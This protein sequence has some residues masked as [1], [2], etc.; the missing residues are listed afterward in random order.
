MRKMFTYLAAFLMIAVTSCTEDVMYDDLVVSVKDLTQRVGEKTAFE[1]KAGSGE[2]E[3]TSANDKIATVTTSKSTATVTGVAA[4]ETT[5][6]VYDR[7]NEQKAVVK[8]TVKKALQAIVVD[9]TEVN[10]APKEAVTLAIKSGNGSYE[11]SVADTKIAKATLQG[12]K[13]V[14]EGT[15]LGTTTLSVKDKESGKAVEVQISVIGKLAVDKKEIATKLNA[16][17]VVTILAGSGQYIV[18]SSDEAIVKPTLSANK[19]SL[20]TLKS[21]EAIITITD[22]KTKNVSDVKVIVYADISVSK[23]Q[24]QLESGKINTEIS[25]TSGSGQYTATSN[26]QNIATVSLAQGKLTIK[27]IAHGT[28]KIV[29]KDSKTEKT[30][31][32]QVTVTVADIT[33]STGSV[34]VKATENATLTAL[35]GSGN[36]QATSSNPTVATVSVNGNNIVINGKIVGSTKITVKDKVSG[37]EKV[38]SVTVTYKRNIVLSQTNL[39]VN[40]GT[41]KNV[42]ISSGSGSYAL[43]SSNSNVATASISGNVI[44]VKGIAAGTAN[45]TVSN[46]IDNPVTLVVKVIPAATTPNG[47]NGSKELAGDLVFVE[48]G[49][50]K[51]GTPSRGDGDELLHTVTLSSFSITK[52]EITNE[53][54]VKFL[55]AKGNQIEGGAKWYQGKDIKQQGNTF[56][57]NPG[58]EKFPAVFITWQGAKA[59]AKWVGG[60]LPTEAEWEYAARGG[61]KSKGYLYSGSN[62]LDEVGWYLS[63]SG[64]RLHAVGEKKPNELGIHDM[65]GNI[66]EWTADWY[67]AYSTAHQTNP[68]GAATGSAR[69]RRGASAFCVPNTN[70]ATNR[71]NRAPTGVRHNLGIRVVFRQ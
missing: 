15:A 57:V 36:Y 32:I 70:R 60:D 62:N 66:W 6:T 17:E 13:I 47:G 33:L 58:R 10:L 56:V 11:L 37:K 26:N 34:N 22:T 19:V 64:G 44:V 4:G 59:F 21:G 31:E 23:N 45:I 55:N 46:S 43:T 9:R 5:V 49:T 39:E 69:V 27:G 67:G 24:I 14:V 65:S 50:F 38:V 40:T 7:G 8:V 16:T 53:Q 18:K 35:S 29:V 51:M 54:F 71:S 12:E 48:G 41:T 30:A 25:I 3:V 61:N 68:T 52:Y 63:N 42:S 2:Y 28:A 20:T 1:I